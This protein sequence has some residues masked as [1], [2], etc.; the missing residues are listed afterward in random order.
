MLLSLISCLIKSLAIK[1]FWLNQSDF[2]AI[3]N[4]VHNQNEDFHN[5]S[6]KSKQMSSRLS[7]KSSVCLICVFYTAMV[8]TNLGISRGLEG[9]TFATTPNSQEGKK[10]SVMW[11]VQKMEQA[12]RYN[13]FLTERNT[14][15]LG[16]NIG[17]GLIAIPA[18]AG[19]IFRNVAGSFGDLFLLMGVLTLWTSAKDFNEALKEKV[20]KMEA[21]WEMVEMNW[22]RLQ[23]LTKLINKAYGSNVTVFIAEVVVYYAISFNQVFIEG[24]GSI[25][26]EL[27]AMIR[28]VLYFG[29]ACFILLLAAD[30]GHQVQELKTWFGR[31]GNRR[32][33][34]QDY[35]FVMLNEVDTGAVAIRGHDVFPV[36]YTLVAN[37]S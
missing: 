7:R 9:S 10:L 18:L 23:M 3:V 2:L 32:Q 26:E 17:T 35:I 1:K 16:C 25:G 15:K 11:W 19:F 12:G 13:F 5:I 6:I 30:V 24:T 33:V 36:T 34:K 29:S 20:G 22:R 28:L 37:V 27:S 14:T 21:K 31:E 8:L 4:F